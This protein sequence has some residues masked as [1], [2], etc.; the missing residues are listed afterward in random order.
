MTRREDDAKAIF[1]A[2]VEAVQADALLG[3][4]ELDKIA[5]RPLAAYRNVFVVAMGKAALAMASVMESSG[6]PITDGCVVVPDGYPASL[7]GRFAVPKAVHIVE[8]GHPLPNERSR[9]AAARILDIAKSAKRDDLF[10]VLISGGGSALC[11]DFQQGVSLEDAQAMYHL[12]LQSGAD[13][14]AMNTVRK[15]ISRVGG[16]RLAE[17]AYPAEVVSMVISD[18]AGDDL[19]VIAGGPTTGDPTTFEDARLV[20]EEHGLWESI[21]SSIRTLVQAGIEN[22]LLDTPKP[23]SRIF[24]RAAN[25]LIGTNMTALEAARTAAVSR[26]YTARIETS[27]MAGDATVAGRMVV[28][29]LASEEASAPV[30]LLFGGETTVEVRGNGR[31][32]RNQELALMAGIELSAVKEGV[33]VLSGGTDGVDGPTDAAGAW[34]TNRS[35]AT[36]RQRGLDPLEYLKNNDSYTFFSRAG[37]LLRTGHTHTNVMDVVVCLKSG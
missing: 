2:A 14:H 31:G 27:G 10:V 17:T 28:G 9:R 22:P 6:V 12:L 18:V 1:E 23:E 16:G 15:H 30:C 3:S 7:P 34:V 11:A 25:H 13:I 37:G 5:S 36:A 8:G 35:I 33:V 20:L 29:R 4:I 26:G 19:S 24:E 21:P 32:G